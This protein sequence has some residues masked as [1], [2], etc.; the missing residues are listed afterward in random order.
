MGKVQGLVGAARLGWGLVALLYTVH[1]GDEVLWTVRG[2]ELEVNGSDVARMKLWNLEAV[3]GVGSVVGCWVENKLSAYVV[4]RAIPEREWLSEKGGVQGLVDGNS[5]VMW[6][7]RQLTVI[8]RAWNRVDV[9]VEIMTAEAAK[10]AVVRGLVYCGM[11][12]TVHMAVG[13]GG[14]SIPRLGLRVSTAETQGAGG[15]PIGPGMDGRMP[16]R[17]PPPRTV[18]MALR[19]PLVGACFKCRRTGH[20][21]NECPD[22][23]GVDTRG[24]FTR[25]WKGHISTDCQRRV[26]MAMPVIGGSKD[27]DRVE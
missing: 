7:P 12:R 23:G 5:G 22:G 2:V 27:K 26:Q 18:G 3:W 8:G 21:K 6:G 17:G 13:G 24:C 19:R 1:G 20:W 11:K 4:V 16:T 9:K 15:R 14:A 10:G 25:G